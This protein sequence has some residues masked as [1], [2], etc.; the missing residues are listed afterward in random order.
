MKNIFGGKTVLRALCVALAIMAA[1]P[2]QAGSK[3]AKR[4]AAKLEF[5][6]KDIESQRS[7]E[8]VQGTAIYG[9]LLFSLR[10]TG[11]C[12]VIDLRKKELVAEFKLDSYGIENHAN[13]AFFG[14]YYYEEG[15]RFPLMYVSQCKSKPV[16]ELQGRGFDDLSR[17]CFVERILTD[18][19]GRPCGTKTVQV[20]AYEPKAWNSRLFEFDRKHPEYLYCF[21]NLTG[22]NRPGNHIQV[23]RLRFPAFDRNQFLV[24]MSEKDVLAEMNMDDVLPAG[25]RGPHQ[26]VL[27]GGV[28][29]D[30]HI[31][32]PV[33]LGTEE[34]PSDLFV[35]DLKYLEDKSVRRCAWYD[36]TD[37]VAC[38]MED[39]DI[40][41]NK[42]VCTTNSHGKVRPVYSFPLKGIKLVDAAKYE[43]EH[44][45]EIAADGSYSIIILGDTHL[46][47]EP[48]ELYHTGY[49]DPNPKRQQNHMN[50]W[51]RNCD[52]W[53]DRCPSMLKRAAELADGSTKMFMQT[54]DMIQGDTGNPESHRL[55]LD[56]TVDFLKSS[57]GDLP[58]VTVIGNH[59]L[60]AAADLPYGY[61]VY[62]DFMPKKI[63]QEL[64]QEV[65]STNFAFHIG[66]DAFIVVN[67]SHPDDA[68]V[69]R[70]LKE[71]E[72]ARYTFV[73]C[74]APFFPYDSKKYYNW[75]YHGKDKS[76]GGNPDHSAR[77]HM[78]EL[79]AKRN[80]IVLCG[81][82]HSTEYLDWYGMGGRITQMT[83]SS[84]WAK[85]SY[86]KYD[87]LYEGAA[88]YGKGVSKTPEMK[89]IFD[90]FRDGIKGYSTSMAIG[91]YK[92][93]V[94]PNG[95]SVDFYAGDSRKVSKTFV[96]R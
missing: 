81:H 76:H 35:V 92:L 23:Q 13:D 4:P 1:A 85:D 43:S 18:A 25:V 47:K 52:M 45:D 56:E 73:L 44:A 30:N 41:G 49:Y 83:M 61:E 88:E 15:D 19:N 17:L 3:L 34:Y 84:V 62:Q 95:V 16:A 77:D 32:M 9:D 6:Q 68:E 8:S 70:L 48:T 11:L 31:Y 93:K 72:G 57:L 63:S 40:W 96:L 14:P 54:G 38:E 37:V 36:Y 79:F 51:Q 27:Q 5:N 64:G 86:A 66:S 80:A 24:N 33:G 71:T 7:H 50:E 53:K 46:D 87:V 28:V 82:T 42:L 58:F 94:G 89:A 10:N 65:N 90:E 67:F 55:F 59:D 39:M 12:V 91:V 2:L 29:Y 74:H 60:R 78:M 26:N 21:G 75:Y 20:I 69:E 22:N